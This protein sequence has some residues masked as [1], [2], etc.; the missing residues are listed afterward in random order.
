MAASLAEIVHVYPSSGG[1][2]HFSHLLAPAGSANYISWICGKL[3]CCFS[4]D[5]SSVD[6]LTNVDLRPRCTGWFAVAGWTALTATTGSL[7]G[8]LLLGAYSLAHPG[9]EAQPYQTFVIYAGYIC[10]K[11]TLSVRCS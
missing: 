2:Y 11:S 8:E 4:I 6:S 9:F 3:F 10:R 7:A 1:P 5:S